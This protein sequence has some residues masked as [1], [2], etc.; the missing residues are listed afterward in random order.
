MYRRRRRRKKR[1]QLEQYLQQLL[2]RCEQGAFEKTKLDEAVFHRIEYIYDSFVERMKLNGRP[3][4]ES[5]QTLLSQWATIL[6]REVP[7]VQPVTRK[8]A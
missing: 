2:Q 3:L 4:T 6:G 5:Q 8:A 1:I 7:D